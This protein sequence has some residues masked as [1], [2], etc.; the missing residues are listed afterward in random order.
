LFALE[1]PRDGRFISIGGES[2]PRRT[3]H[4]SLIGASIFAAILWAVVGCQRQADSRTPSP[5]EQN[6]FE[7]AA[8]GEPAVELVIDYGDG[9][10]KRFTR[11]PHEDGMT[12]LAALGSAAKHPRGIKFENTGSGAAALVRRIDDVANESSRDGK[13][14]LYRINGK[15]A[16]KSAGAYVLSPGDVILWRFEEY[17]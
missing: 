7:L 13:N 2:M 4:L 8:E 16:D 1:L 5:A 12:A 3:A 10:Q 14:W 15:L 9:V 6:A 11:I 17:E